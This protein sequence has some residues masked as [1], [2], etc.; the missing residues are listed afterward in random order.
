MTQIAQGKL[1]VQNGKIIKPGQDQEMEVENFREEPSRMEPDRNI[2]DDFL[3]NEDD[4]VFNIEPEMSN[5]PG[6]ESNLNDMRMEEDKYN[7][8]QVSI[9]EI[10]KPLIS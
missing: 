6:M 9:Y 7:E 10:S 1:T 5:N 8:L 4:D 3:Q 2:A